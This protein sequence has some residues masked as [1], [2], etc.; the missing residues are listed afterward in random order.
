MRYK[1][2]IFTIIF[3]VGVVG[4][5]YFYLRSFNVTKKVSPTP[6][7]PE[8]TK[9]TNDIAV[10]PSDDQLVQM[11]QG[12]IEMGRSE[13]STYSRF[14]ANLE[15]IILEK[16]DFNTLTR[17]LNLN[18]GSKDKKNSQKIYILDPVIYTKDLKK[19]EFSKLNIGDKISI[20]YT[21]D[22]KKNTRNATLVYTND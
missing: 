18:I 17:T 8:P 12:Y 4:V 14:E 11:A 7:I 22:L 20:K 9:K 5:E 2:L 19:S 3:L 10:Q 1:V 21:Y 16:P 6:V 13:L 15:G